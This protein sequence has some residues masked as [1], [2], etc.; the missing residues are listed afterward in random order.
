LV[1]VVRLRIQGAQA[2]GSTGWRGG[3]NTQIGQ[4]P[5]VEDSDDP[6]ADLPVQPSGDPVAA[7]PIEQQAAFLQALLSPKIG[8]SEV[9]ILEG[10]V[11]PRSGFVIRHD[12]YKSTVSAWGDSVDQIAAEACRIKGISAY[13]TVNPVKRDLLARAD[14][15]VKCRSTTTDADI[16]CLSWLFLDFDVKRPNGISSTD[17]EHATARERLFRFLT[18]YPDIAASS[19]WGSSGN[20]YWLTVRLADYPN[21]EEH[22]NLIARVTDWVS[23]NYSDAAVEVD[24]ATKN[25][26]RVMPLVGTLKCKGVSTEDRP[27]RQVTLDT[28]P[29]KQFPPFDLVAFA[30]EKI[31]PEEPAQPAATAD[32][33]G[34]PLVMTYTSGADPE[35]RARAYVFSP[36]FPDSVAGENGHGRLYHVACVLVDGFGLPQFQAAQIL[37]DWNAQKASP[38]EDDKQ[39]THKLNDAIKNHPAPSLKLLNADRGG[40]TAKQRRPPGELDAKLAKRPKTDLGNGERLVARF[41]ARIRYCHPWKKWMHYDRQRWKED[42]TAAVHQ[43][44]KRTVRAIPKEAATLDDKD[45]IKAHNQFWLASEARARVEAMLSSASSEN[46]IPILPD[47]MDR[48]RFLLNVENGT[49]DLRT[50]KLRPHQRE[51]LITKLAPVKFLPGSTCPTWHRVLDRIFAGDPGLIKFWKTLCG[52]CLTGD[53]SNQILPVLYGSGANGKTT[54]LTVLLEILGPDYAIVAPPGL[55]TLKKGDRHPTELASLF[56]KRLVIDS[57]TAEG[58]QFNENLVKQLTGSDKIRARRMREDFWEFSPTHKILMCTNHKPEIRETKYA[59]WRRVKAVPFNVTIPD[60]EQDAQLPD[61]LRAEYPGILAWCVE[62]CLDWLEMGLEIPAAVEDATA[63]Y[64][65]ESDVI[66]EFVASECSVM[67]ELRA[68]ANALYARYQKWA[69]ADAVNQRKFGKAMTERGFRKHTNNGTEYL[70]VGLRAEGT[71]GSYQGD[72]E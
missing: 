37:R 19:M 44:A 26:A 43:L 23:E 35:T 28:S 8:C 72:D 21:D 58:A 13:I 22:R 11:D 29:D 17:A 53:V 45:E 51:D 41:G 34:G 59:I 24:P 10:N 25:P 62:G 52:I 2:A 30:A 33:D 61:K 64:R 1:L 7:G 55:L 6:W 70:G 38:P 49:I 56:N 60:E 40:A 67:P 47:D 54:I 20:G 65:R 18:D 32:D 57:E 66:G 71:E 16:A 50:G 12:T 9:R 39:L 42:G 36:G 4:P 68:R 15:L 31:P 69:G 5:P 48:D 46:G 14:R 3:L 63:E 27:F